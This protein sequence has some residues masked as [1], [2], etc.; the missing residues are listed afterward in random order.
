MTNCLQVLHLFVVII[1]KIHLQDN[2]LRAQPCVNN[3]HGDP[4]FCVNVWTAGIVVTIDNEPT[5]STSI[6][7]RGLE[8]KS[9]AAQTIK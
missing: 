9:H 5:I 3:H 8:L 6:S 4:C 7:P 1:V 2:W